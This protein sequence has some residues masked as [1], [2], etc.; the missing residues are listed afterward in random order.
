MDLLQI[1][2]LS[3]LTRIGVYAWEQQILQRL[4]IDISIP[5][6]FN[7]CHDDIANTTDYDKLCQQVTAYVSCNAFHLIET[8]A[9]NVANFIKQEFNIP[10]L[11]VS[12][13]K[14]HAVKNASDI[15]ITVTR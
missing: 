8:V 9:D 5:G 13:S 11:T 4:L 1:K 14:P 10:Q 15:R 12:V 3:V 7:A 6:N 2:G